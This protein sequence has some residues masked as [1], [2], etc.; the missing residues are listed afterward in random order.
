[1]ARPE[2]RAPQLVKP[3]SPPADLSDA[4]ACVWREVV[5]TWD[6]APTALELLARGLADLDLERKAREQVR[7]EGI[8]VTNPTSGATRAHPAIAVAHACLRSARLIF[9]H[10]DLEM[11]DPDPLP[12]ARGSRS[13]GR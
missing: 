6:L 10:L 5:E 3:P 9:S 12:R 4:G 1:M 8:V 13:R 7:R 11:P 2:T